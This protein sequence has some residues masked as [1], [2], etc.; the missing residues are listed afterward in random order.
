MLTA[1]LES[2]TV[3]QASRR[4]QGLIVP[5]RSAEELERELRKEM[6]HEKTHADEKKQENH[7]LPSLNW[8]RERW[9]DTLR[10]LPTELPSV[11]ASEMSQHPDWSYVCAIRS[12]YV[13]CEYAQDVPHIG[14]G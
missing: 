4:T 10:D 8:S 2:Q 12:A 14:L 11:A 9:E 7:A 13:G 1:Q 3:A 6:E 5:S